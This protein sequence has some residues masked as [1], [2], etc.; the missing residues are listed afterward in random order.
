MA[1]KGGGASKRPLIGP[2]R[3]CHSAQTPRPPSFSLAVTKSRRLNLTYAFHY[4][5]AGRDH[6]NRNSDENDDSSN[7]NNSRSN[8]NNFNNERLQVK[9]NVVMKKWVEGKDDQEGKKNTEGAMMRSLAYAVIIRRRQLL[10][11]PTESSR[12]WNTVTASI[13]RH[14]TPIF[15]LKSI[16]AANVDF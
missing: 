3:N 13:R 8:N 1:A 11:T 14:A 16:I 10:R 4:L 6:D 15:K 2:L 12:L 7:N 5:A 9:P